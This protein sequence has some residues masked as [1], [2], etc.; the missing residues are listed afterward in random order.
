[1]SLAISAFSLP[2]R[3]SKIF[4]AELAELWRSSQSVFEPQHLVKLHVLKLAFCDL[5]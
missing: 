4:N 2:T 1:M 5:R 3:R